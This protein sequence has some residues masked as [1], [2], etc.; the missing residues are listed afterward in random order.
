MA[1][2][3]V[4]AFQA[5][6]KGSTASTAVSKLIN[7]RLNTSFEFHNLDLEVSRHGGLSTAC[8]LS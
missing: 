3:A 5:G 2:Y 6:R 8:P 1:Y 4:Q 7:V